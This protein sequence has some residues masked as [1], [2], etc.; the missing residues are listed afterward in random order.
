MIQPPRCAPTWFESCPRRANHAGSCSQKDRITW[1]TTHKNAAAPV[2]VNEV[3]ADRNPAAAKASGTRVAPA[4]PSA[5]AAP[6]RVVR[7][8][9]ALKIATKKDA[10][11]DRAKANSRSLVRRSPAADN[12]AAAAAIASSHLTAI[13]SQIRRQHDRTWSCPVGLLV[14]DLYARH[15]LSAAIRTHLAPCC[16]APDWIRINGLRLRRFMCDD[17]LRPPL[18]D[19]TDHPR[20]LADDLGAL[21]GHERA[22]VSMG[23]G[24]VGFANAAICGADSSRSTLHQIVEVGTSAPA[25]G[26]TPTVAP[27]MLRRAPSITIRSC[28]D[29]LRSAARAVASP[30]CCLGQRTTFAAA[31]R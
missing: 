19:I 22:S 12:K 25:E 16:G 29:H 3:R 31:A 21:S 4:L 27:W 2:R 20:K 14:I 28:C 7:A 26:A 9:Q 15:G 18:T 13:H 17:L 6:A 24:Q 30:A 23:P 10:L 8:R 11:M 5:K 1:Q